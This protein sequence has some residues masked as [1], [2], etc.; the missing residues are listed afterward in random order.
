MTD[1]TY[2][3]NLVEMLNDG[4]FE[5]LFTKLDLDNV[6]IN[7]EELELEIPIKNSTSKLIMCIKE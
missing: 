5:E 3:P 7:E 4:N 1:D 6:I 2:Y